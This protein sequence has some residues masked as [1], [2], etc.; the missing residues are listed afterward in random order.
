MRHGRQLG[1]P[2][3]LDEQVARTRFRW[4]QFDS[5][6]KSGRLTITG[7]VQPTVL[8][9]VYVVRVE[10]ERGSAPRAFVISPELRSRP[11]EG[12]PHVYHG[13]RPCLYL[14]RAREWTSAM[15]I[16]STIIPWLVVWLFYYE[17]WHAT[18]TWLGG[19]EHPLDGAK[20]EEEPDIDEDTE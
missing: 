15:P 18:G 9:D 7:C 20:L 6:I 11:D 16:A 8:S 1:R 2:L 10:Y 19:G 4:P 17:M 14:P 3:T 5:R 12:I 13:P